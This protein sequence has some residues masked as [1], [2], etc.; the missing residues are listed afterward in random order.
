MKAINFMFSK[1]NDE[2]RAMHSKSDN[3]GIL[4][5]DEIDEVTGVLFQSLLSRYQTW[6]KASIQGSNVMFSYV[7]VFHYKSHTL[8]FKLG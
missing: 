5:N 3:L 6:L 4:T 7:Y 8:N 2:G 1:D